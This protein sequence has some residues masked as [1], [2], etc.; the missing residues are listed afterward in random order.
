[1]REVTLEP[2]AEKCLET[3]EGASGHG[4]KVEEKEG[5]L[6]GKVYGAWR[7]I[8]PPKSLLQGSLQY[9][10][11]HVISLS[12]RSHPLGQVSSSPPKLALRNG[13]KQEE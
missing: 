8:S 13:L 9:H 10:M 1:M 4:G 2:V 6:D 12:L 11:P 3:L 5:I 7:S